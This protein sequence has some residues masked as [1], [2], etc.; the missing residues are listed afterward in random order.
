MFVSLAQGLRRLS[1]GLLALLAMAVSPAS[2]TTAS[3]EE[4]NCRGI[5]AQ[6]RVPKQN[7]D[8][9]VPDEFQLELD[10]VS[11]EALVL[12]GA[13]QC[14]LLAVGAGKG[15]KTEFVTF[16]ISLL[17]PDPTHRPPAGYVPLGHAYTLWF[18]SDNRDMVEYYRDHGDVPH[19]AA[20]YDKELSIKMPGEHVV[21][22]VESRRA[23]GPV[24]LR[25]AGHARAARDR[26]PRRG[27]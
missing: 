20:V 25:D 22:A 19:H 1:L 14:D 13:V 26:G 12:V 5:Q 9:L 15:R 4:N 8:P 23:L 10:P 27:R 11:G 16:R 18:A 24:A 3:V 21:R 6:I 17:D 2:A 7:V